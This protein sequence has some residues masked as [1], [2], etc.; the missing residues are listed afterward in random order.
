MYRP[1]CITEAY[2]GPERVLVGMC[3]A[4]GKPSIQFKLHFFSDG[5]KATAEWEAVL[6]IYSA[7][8]QYHS[9]A[10]DGCRASKLA[11][12]VAR[13]YAWKKPQ[14]ANF[15]RLKS[16][17][18]GGQSAGVQNSANSHWAVL[19][20]LTGVKSAERQDTTSGPKGTHAVS[21]A[22]GRRW[23][24]HVRQQ[25]LTIGSLNL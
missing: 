15:S 21:N 25:K 8:D 24:W 5:I 13:T 7:A 19:A 23:H 20:V 2:G 4:V 3:W 12:G 9:V 11:W 1:S 22:L 18:Y 17:E 14:V 6:R 16:S 10:M